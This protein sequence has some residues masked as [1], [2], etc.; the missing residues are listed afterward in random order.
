MGAATPG[1]DNTRQESGIDHKAEITMQSELWSR[2]VLHLLNELIHRAN[3]NRPPHSAD[4]WHTVAE[5]FC[6]SVSI[7]R[8]RSRQQGVLLDDII[9]VRSSPRPTVICRRIAHEIA[10]YLLKSEWEAPYHVPVHD[11]EQER[12]RI[13][14]TVENLLVASQ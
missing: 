7:E 4:D 11:T 8:V 14:R 12:H 2:E 3:Y 10:E 1:G 13:A 5:R 9:V 6:L